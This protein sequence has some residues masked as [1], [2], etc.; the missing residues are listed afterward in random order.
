[1]LFFIIAHN[2][3]FLPNDS[4]YYSA[5]VWGQKETFPFSFMQVRKSKTIHSSEAVYGIL[6]M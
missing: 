4:K 3:T 6:N 2:N 1:M 5:F